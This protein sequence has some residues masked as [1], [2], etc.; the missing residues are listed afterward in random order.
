MSTIYR[1]FLVAIMAALLVACSDG[2]SPFGNTQGPKKPKALIE[3]EELKAKKNA[4][5][6]A[7]AEQANPSP[8]EPAPAEAAKP[9][10]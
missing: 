9:A 8:S 6:K 2:G 10:Q 3:A 4:A 5:D 1:V 7:A